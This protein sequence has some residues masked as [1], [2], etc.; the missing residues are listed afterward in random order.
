MSEMLDKIMDGIKAVAPTVANIALPGSGLLVHSLIRAVAG[1]EP[2]VPVEQSAARIAA[3]PD[4]MLEFQKVCVEREIA[5]RNAASADLAT[6]NL[7]MQAEGKSEHWPQYTWRP[8]N[9]FS[10]PLA[11]WTIYFILPMLSKTVPSVP[12][13]VWIGWL[14]ILGV[15]T[16]DR[17]KEKRIK[18]GEE[19]RPGLVESAINAIKG[20]TG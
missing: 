2:D 7:T 14:A 16:W 4:L 3:N 15:A 18:V 1:D 17:G 13:M 9:G 12:E 6:V 8:F 19:Q 5:L 11:V 10:F 20:K